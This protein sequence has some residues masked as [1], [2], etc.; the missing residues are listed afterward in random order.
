MGF[1]DTL[2]SPFKLA[3]NMG[4]KA[5]HAVGSG[6]KT[7]F[8][9]GESAVKTVY[10]DVIQEPKQLLNNVEKDVTGIA[11]NTIHTAGNAIGDIS[12]VLKSPIILIAAGAGLIF[13]SKK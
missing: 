8:N 3:F 4:K 2:A 10:H 7:I 12:S 9:K 5:V 11:N 6:I 13:L 1:W